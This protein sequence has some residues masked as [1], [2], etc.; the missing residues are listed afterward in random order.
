MSGQM[1]ETITF[2][3]TKEANER[4]SSED[5]LLAAVQIGFDLFDPLRTL[6]GHSFLHCF[7]YA[8]LS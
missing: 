2:H 7:G 1:S 8:L 4:L 3:T 5:R 6:K